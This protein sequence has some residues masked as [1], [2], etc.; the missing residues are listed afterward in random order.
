M[1]PK[2]SGDKCKLMQSAILSTTE[3]GKQEFESHLAASAEL[4]L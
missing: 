4:S 2:D 1:S 3:P